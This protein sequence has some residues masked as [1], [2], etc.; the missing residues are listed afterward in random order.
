MGRA[1]SQDLQCDACIC[2]DRALLPQLLA[3]RIR[4]GGL[5]SPWT[6][7]QNTSTE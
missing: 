1:D 7:A 4:E 3:E 5:G 2:D 6:V